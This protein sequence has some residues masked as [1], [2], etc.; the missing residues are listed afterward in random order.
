M[1]TSIDNV[2]ILQRM[3]QQVTTSGLSIKGVRVS[4]NVRVR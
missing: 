3:N 1:N 4:G 2:Y